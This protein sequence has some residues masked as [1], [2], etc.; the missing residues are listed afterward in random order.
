MLNITRYTYPSITPALIKR[1]IK[2]VDKIYEDKI[3]KP[4]A[5]T[6]TLDILFNEKALHWNKDWLILRDTFLY[7]INQYLGINF[8]YYK[9]WVYASF[10]GI[11]VV[12]SQWHIHPNSRFSGVMYLTLPKDN[13]DQVCYTTEFIE[14]DNRTTMLEPVIGSWFVFDSRR[15][16]RPGFWDYE[17]M[18]NKRYCLA[19][20]VW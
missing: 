2:N 12:G 10:P 17:N 7:S 20:S 13:Y 11:P 5:A 4:R 15:L 16:H 9:A 19:A 6:Q 3:T 8:N 1:A 18:K 14:K